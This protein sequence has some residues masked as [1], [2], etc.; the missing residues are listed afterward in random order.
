MDA[1]FPFNVQFSKIGIESELNSSIIF[2]NFKSNVIMSST[3]NTEECY[4]S[5]CTT[6]L[7]TCVLGAV[8]E[9][10]VRWGI[11]SKNSAS[12]TKKNKNKNKKKQANKQTKKQN[13]KFSV[14]MLTSR[15][16]HSHFC[17]FFV[18]NK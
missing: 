5:S 15:A 17:Q 6:C 4:G 9:Q 12:Q 14:V 1:Y 3:L 8:S 16:L 10:A 7:D 13:G 18:R 11:L 2:L